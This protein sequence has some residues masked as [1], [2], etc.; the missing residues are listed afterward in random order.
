MLIA[1]VFLDGLQQ[2][3]FVFLPPVLPFSVHCSVAEVV[4]TV[5]VFGN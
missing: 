1:Y 3:I 5:V 4:K 2:S